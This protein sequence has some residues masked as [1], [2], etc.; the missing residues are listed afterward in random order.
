MCVILFADGKRPSETMVGKSFLQN[1]YG[2]GIAWREE[3]DGQVVVKWKKG[4]E[5]EEAQEMVKKVP[6]PFV[7]HF[8]VPSMGGP[9]KSLNHPFPVDTGAKLDFDGQTS[10]SVLFHNGT[11]SNWRQFCLDTASRQPEKFPIGRWSDSRGMAWCASV[12]GLGVLELIN[13]KVIVFGPEKI[14]I[15]GDGWDEEDGIFVSNKHWKSQEYPV[16]PKGNSTSTPT[17][18]HGAGSASTTPEKK[19]I[20]PE[21]TTGTRLG[22]S[23]GAPHQETFRTPQG[24][25]NECVGELVE[26]PVERG[27]EPVRENAEATSGEGWVS[28]VRESLDGPLVETFEA[29]RVLHQSV[30]DA[31]AE[32]MQDREAELKSWALSLQP[33][34]RL[35]NFPDDRAE[36]ARRLE[37]Q[38]LGI[39]HMGAL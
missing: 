29:E 14:D 1:K 20:F 25:T 34:G 21:H 10:G 24:G 8:R 30:A 35:V 12:Y 27:A 36:R 17:Q 32:G 38:R 5:L 13:E 2:A 11:W 16:R 15:F 23:G 3:V 18:Y 22:V 39:I 37:N 9:H 31:V 6:M 4:M 19:L 28:C 7:V 26:E 33:K